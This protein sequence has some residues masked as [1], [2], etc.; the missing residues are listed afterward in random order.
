MKAIQSL[1]TPLRLALVLFVLCG[2]L[3]P[4]A[5]TGLARLLFPHQAGGSLLQVGDKTLGSRL[6][7]QDFTDPRFMKGR[8]SAVQYN[9]YTQE[10][11]DSGAFAGLHSGS[12]NLG[13]SDPALKARI[14]RDI[15]AF[16]EA[17]AAPRPQDLPADL[18]TQSGSG[19][20][21]HISPAAAQLQIP[22]L[23]QA[24]GLSEQELRDIVAQNTQGRGLGIFGEET[25]QVLGVNLEI[26]RRLE[27][28]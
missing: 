13:P 5:S 18:F 6:V 22:D 23:A 27:L 20:D 19:L 4:L 21:P 1:K 17:S 28:L 3:Y 14:A 12:D 2:V 11:K 16:F 8:P 15:A 25:V 26:A 10:E 9:T 24:T 7:G